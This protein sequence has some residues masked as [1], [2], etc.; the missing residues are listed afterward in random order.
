MH[1]G[2]R[3]ARMGLALVG[4][5]GALGCPAH[6]PVPDAPTTRTVDGGPQVGTLP[7]AGAVRGLRSETPINVRHIYSQIQAWTVDGLYF[8]AV[9][10]LNGEGV[11]LKTDDWQEVARVQHGG[12]RW[13][14]GTHKVLTFD[15]ASGAALFVYD[16]DTGAESQLLALGH[17]GLESGRSQEEVDRSGQ[18]VA[19]YID[20]AASGGPRVVTVDLQSPQVVLDISIADLGCDGEPD[21]VGVDPTGKFLLVQAVRDGRAQCSGL[22]AYDIR[23][24]APVHQLTQHHNHGSTGLGPNGRP[25]FLSTEN[26]HPSD[27]NNPGIFRYWIDTAER[28]VVGQSIPWGSMD[29]V[30]CLGGPGAACIVTGGNEFNNPYTGQLWRLDFDGTRAVIEPHEAP[31]NCGYWGQSQATAGPAGRYAFATH[32]GNCEAIRDRV[33][34]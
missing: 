29:H 4:L 11:V 7:D 31:S 28:E 2:L 8:L 34:Q 18:W 5:M 1:H 12:H 26:A 19:V 6:V 17:P 21:W 16:V 22:W 23:T 32:G 10:V 33:V 30:S 25:Y 3:S 9:D 20:S 15:E 27:N 24:G 13:I 14:T